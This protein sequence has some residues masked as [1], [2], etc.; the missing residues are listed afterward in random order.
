MLTHA[1]IHEKK[2]D[3]EMVQRRKAIRRAR[4]LM[5]YAL[6]HARTVSAAEQAERERHAQERRQ[7]EADRVQM[8]VKSQESMVRKAFNRVKAFIR[9]RNP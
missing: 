7:A 2:H 3:R 9:G 8:R 5:S 6:W 4:N 1:R